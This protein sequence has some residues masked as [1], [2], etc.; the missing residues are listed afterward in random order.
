MACSCFV[1]IL[2]S[3]VS[4]TIDEILS[5]HS[6]SEPFEGFR[7]GELN[8]FISCYNSCKKSLEC[9][10]TLLMAIAGSDF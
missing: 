8:R 7:P 1:N 10:L 9:A 2:I 5:S 6:I 3:R 4:S